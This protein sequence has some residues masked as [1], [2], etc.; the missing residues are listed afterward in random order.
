MLFLQK[1]IK[2]LV[3]I[4][5]T[6]IGL[7]LIATIFNYL[8]IISYKII[9]ILKFIIPIIATISGG[10]IIGKHSEK[11]GWLSGLKLGLIFLILL[12]LFN[13][14]GFQHKLQ[15]KNFIYYLILLISTIIGSMIG[16]NIKHKNV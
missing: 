3:I 15:L 4:L 7:T 8:N 11:N 12:I 2:P 10:F 9:K 13:L 16:I 5:L 14:L 6:I 1:S